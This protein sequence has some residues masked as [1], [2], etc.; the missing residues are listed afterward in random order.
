MWGCVYAGEVAADGNIYSMEYF[1]HSNNPRSLL[2]ISLSCT[3]VTH[4]KDSEIDDEVLFDPSVWSL[5]IGGTSFGVVKKVQPSGPDDIPLEIFLVIPRDMTM[6]DAYQVLMS[7][8]A[9][10]PYW[11]R[12][13]GHRRHWINLMTYSG[14][15][16]GQ[17]GGIGTSQLILENYEGPI[18]PDNPEQMRKVIRRVRKDYNLRS[19]RVCGMRFKGA[20]FYSLVRDITSLMNSGPGKGKS[21][22]R[23][24]VL[25]VLHDGR[26][27]SNNELSKEEFDDFARHFNRIMLL[28][29][30][31]APM[32]WASK[33]Y[34]PSPALQTLMKRHVVAVLSSGLLSEC[35]AFKGVELCL[36]TAERRKRQQRVG[37][38]L[39]RM[40]GGFLPST[41]N[42]KKFISRSSLI[43]LLS[44]SA[45]AGSTVYRLEIK[46][47]DSIFPR[48][49]KI[50]KFGCLLRRKNKGGLELLGGY[51]GQ[52]GKC[53]GTEVRELNAETMAKLVMRNSP[54]AYSQTLDVCFG[55]SQQDILS[56]EVES[57]IKI[58]RRV[59]VQ[60]SIK[61]R[62]KA[63]DF[64]N[65]LSA[66]NL[67]E[68]ACGISSEAP[69]RIQ[70]LEQNNEQ[71][72]L[73]YK[74]AVVV[75][76][77]LGLFIGWFAQGR[78]FIRRW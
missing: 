72:I 9:D 17:G 51:S 3:D 21:E 26:N 57:I 38:L 40:P 33:V 14:C 42:H 75:S 48:P 18:S 2:K 55:E 10:F 32:I 16:G 23:G 61:D 77:I 12:A 62:V 27:V 64:L 28:Q 67:I 13:L 7:Q 29:P 25:V 4:T 60:R 30:D 41:F 66:D 20:E 76:G 73:R 49:S 1:K 37:E 53:F 63:Q 56:G 6:L 65:K 45:Q 50:D 8:V 59:C 15:K 74:W 34:R 35:K 39:N 22:G 54:Y 47:I 44:G 70:R 43:S 58:N 31:I 69:A 24:R 52:P 71:T 5:V 19:S 68:T 46:K 11:L 78:R 36:S